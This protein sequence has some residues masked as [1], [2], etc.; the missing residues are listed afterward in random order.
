MLEAKHMWAYV[1]SQ[2]VIYLCYSTLPICATHG[3]CKHGSLN[4]QTKSGSGID[5]RQLQLRCNAVTLLVRGRSK[6]TLL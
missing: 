5:G 4:A 1:T 6:T 3:G 2:L